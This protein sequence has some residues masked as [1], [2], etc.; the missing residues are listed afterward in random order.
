MRESPPK[1]FRQWFDFYQK[2]DALREDGKRFSS[3][4]LTEKQKIDGRLGMMAKSFA[5]YHHI[6]LQE[7]LIKISKEAEKN[8]KKVKPFEKGS[9]PLYNH[10]GI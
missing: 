7:E 6:E 2:R 9:T 4:G 8:L 5:D 10:K 1:G 3:S